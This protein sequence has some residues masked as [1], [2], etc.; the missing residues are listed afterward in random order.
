MCMSVRTR[1]LPPP[2]L[3]M[4]IFMLFFWPELSRALDQFELWN[5]PLKFKFLARSTVLQRHKPAHYSTGNTTRTQIS[6]SWIRISCSPWS[7]SPKPRMH[8][9]LYLRQVNEGLKNHDHWRTKHFD[10]HLHLDDVY[11]SRCHC[12]ALRCLHMELMR[13]VVKR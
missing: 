4:I 7:N 11:Q 5:H 3:F 9:L 2:W 10:C 1:Q 13:T 12:D 8:A 6:G